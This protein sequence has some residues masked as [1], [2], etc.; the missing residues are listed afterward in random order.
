MYSPLISRKRKYIGEISS[1]FLPH[2]PTVCAV[3]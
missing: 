3:G 2:S 1:Y